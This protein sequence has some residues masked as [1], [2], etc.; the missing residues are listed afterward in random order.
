MKEKE[1]E[2]ELETADHLNI[3]YCACKF[4]AGD[5]VGE[6]HYVGAQQGLWQLIPGVAAGLQQFV[7]NIA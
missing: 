7:Y 6:L 2:K 3:A 5:K 1:S 4:H